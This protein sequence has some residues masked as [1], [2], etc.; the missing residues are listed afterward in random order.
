MSL[1]TPEY[2]G[3]T[4]DQLVA[5]AV[6]TAADAIRRKAGVWSGQDR[7]DPGRGLIETCTDMLVALRDRINLAPDQR[8]LQVLS[9]LGVQP[10]QPS[11]AQTEVVF[12]LAAPPP[13]PVVVPAGLE[14]ATRP[15]GDEEPVVFSTLTEAV[16]NPCVLV[17]AGSF[18]ERRTGSGAL[19]GTLTGL[20]PDAGKPVD[21]VAPAYAGPPL[22]LNLPYLEDFP[23]PGDAADGLGFRPASA[24]AGRV[25]TSSPA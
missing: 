12:R 15:V 13:E 8:R 2:D 10:Y 19:E 17:A 20:G 16:L 4:R 1:P 22:H 21:P 23:A 18:R 5:A 24:P 3:R 25:A 11:P 9:M 6:A 14:V 7:T